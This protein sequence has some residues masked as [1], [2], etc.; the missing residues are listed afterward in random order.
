VTD[1]N[2]DLAVVRVLTVDARF[3]SVVDC[4][5]AWL[6]AYD[7]AHQHGADDARALLQAAEAWDRT[8]AEWRSRTMDLGQPSST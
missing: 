5:T 4:A 2:L 7:D 6:H 3:T 8:A 1:F